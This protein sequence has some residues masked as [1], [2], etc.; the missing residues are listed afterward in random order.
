[1]AEP[2]DGIV[3]PEASSS[4]RRAVAYCAFAHVEGL[5]RPATGINAAPVQE[6]VHDRLRVL[7]S[8]VEWPFAPALLQ[9]HAVE[10]HDVVTQVFTTIAVAPFPLLTIFP[11]LREL[12]D[13]VAARAGGIMADLDRLRD[14]VQ[15]EC[16]LYVIG[17]RARAGLSGEMRGALAHSAAQLELALAAFGAETRIREVKSGFRIFTLVRRGA[18]AQFQGVVNEIMLPKQISRRTSG[19]RPAVEFLTQPLKP[20]STGKGE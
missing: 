12:Q 15:M 7:W 4:G 5:A 1:V 18:E 3:A 6:I 8:D 9:R 20:S 17:D 19:P 11:G 16:V 14:L 2:N 13:F 10:F